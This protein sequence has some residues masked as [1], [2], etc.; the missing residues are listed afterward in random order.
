MNYYF[1]FGQSHVQND[2]T[3]MKDYYVRVVADDYSSARSMFIN[4][5]SSQFMPAPDKWAFQYDEE[6][7]ESHHF[8]KG[9]YLLIQ[10]QDA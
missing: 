2:G 4:E 8:P 5:F 10:H 9:E 1:T 3:P 6:N 7:F